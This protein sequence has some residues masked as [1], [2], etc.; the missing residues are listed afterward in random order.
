MTFGSRLV[1]V[2]RCVA[3]DERGSP[4]SIVIRLEIV[5]VGLGLK[6]GQYLL[7]G[8][9]CR[10]ADGSPCRVV[11]DDTFEMEPGVH[12]RR[13]DAI[14]AVDVPVD[15][16]SSAWSYLRSSGP[17]VEICRRPFRAPSGSFP[18]VVI[19]Q[20]VGP[21]SE[22]NAAHSAPTL[23]FRLPD[24]RLCW[25]IDD[26]SVEP[27]SPQ[28]IEVA[29]GSAFDFGSWRTDHPTFHVEIARIRAADEHGSEH[30]ILVREM[31]CCE[32]M[33][34]PARV[35][36]SP[37]GY[38]R[39]VEFETTEGEACNVL[40]EGTFEVIPDGPFVYRVRRSANPGDV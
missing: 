26:E 3:R 27:V 29:C 39:V 16:H 36:L 12:A 37:R 21:Y 33:I 7:N 24:G 20:G 6:P 14:R 28:D 4:H 25:L 31:I 22:R 38:S 17:A 13:S 8:L 19:R 11:D 34:S 1:Q 2:E 35:W 10:T 9:S 40:D 32:R 5:P 23:E 15:E 30:T 18:T